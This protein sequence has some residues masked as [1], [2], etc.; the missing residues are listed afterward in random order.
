MIM[1][2]DSSPLSFNIDFNTKQNM[3]SAQVL[4]KRANRMARVELGA[5]QPILGLLG[6]VGVRFGS[7]EGTLG[8]IEEIACKPSNNGFSCSVNKTKYD[9]R[10]PPKPVA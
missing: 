6:G 4:D 5:L 2:P 1:P 8:Q 10:L 7:A 9:P 3:V